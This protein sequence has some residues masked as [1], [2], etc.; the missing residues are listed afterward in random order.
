MSQEEKIGLILENY[1]YK[2]FKHVDLEHSQNDVEDI[3]QFLSENDF[4][5]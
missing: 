5:I 4:K 2:S 3:K 1:E